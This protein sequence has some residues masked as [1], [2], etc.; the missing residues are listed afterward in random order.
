MLGPRTSRGGLM[1]GVAYP[2]SLGHCGLGSPFDLDG[3]LWDP[4]TGHDG[5][6]GPLTEA[7]EGEL[8]NAT[9]GTVTL[10]TSDVAEFRT[11]SGAIVTLVR[12]PGERAYPLCQ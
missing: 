11:P 2:Y 12:L 6:G 10:V 4:V 5:S 9:A 3:S 8:I 7:H 1:P